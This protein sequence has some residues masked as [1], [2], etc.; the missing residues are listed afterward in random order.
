MLIKNLFAKKDTWVKDNIK[1]TMVNY[2][3]KYVG[4]LYYIQ[5]NTYFYVNILEEKWTRS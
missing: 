5:P 4:K 2:S 3:S 1:S